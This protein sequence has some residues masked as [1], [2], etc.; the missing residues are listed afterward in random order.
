MMPVLLS[1]L[2]LAAAQSPAGADREQPASQEVSSTGVDFPSLLGGTPLGSGG[3]VLLAEMGFPLAS[4]AY[5]QGLAEE[6]DLGIQLEV[7][8]AASEFLVAGTWRIG[9][10][11][12]DRSSFALRTRAGFYTDFGARYVYLDNLSDT[13]VQAAF[14]LAFSIATGSGLLSFG[15]DL[16][17]TMTFARDKGWVLAPEG[18][19]SFE[20][21]LYGDLTVG[22]RT[23]AGYRIAGGGAPSSGPEGERVIVGLGLL[24]GYRFF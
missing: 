9:L 10:W 1:M 5:S 22:A 3:S 2:A 21:P 12:S 20:V 16:P 6:H 4:V 19:I 11:R 24:I 8:W 17:A 7:N 14:G 13:G 15:A 23:R 18:T